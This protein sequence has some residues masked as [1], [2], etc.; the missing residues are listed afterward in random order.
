MTLDLRG[1]VCPFTLI[2]L[3]REVKKIKKS[4]GKTVLEVLVTDPSACNSIPAW[5]ESQGHRVL[6]IV[7]EGGHF[8]ITVDLRGEEREA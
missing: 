2:L 3:Q 7:D 8:K 6:G 1:M 4:K 5:A